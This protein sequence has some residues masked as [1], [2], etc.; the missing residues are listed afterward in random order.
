MAYA[1]LVCFLRLSGKRTLSKLSAF[2]LV[3]T[4]A[5]GST[6]ATVILSK[7]IALVD[8]LFALALLIGLQYTVAWLSV[9]ARAFSRLVKNEPTLLLYEGAFLDVAMR[10]ARITR[11]EMLAAVRA[12]GVEDLV[13]LRAVVLE[14]DGGLSVVPG[15]GSHPLDSALT[16]LTGPP[17]SAA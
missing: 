11:D 6:L 13:G 4:V 15:R 10:R 17:E 1:A 8:G 14:T 9:R 3:V 16:S 2:D 5:L 7:D 12:Q